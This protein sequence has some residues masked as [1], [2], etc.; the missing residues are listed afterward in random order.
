MGGGRPVFAALVHWC[1]R[2]HGGFKPQSVLP[3]QW[4]YHIRIIN[5]C[6]PQFQ[7]FVRGLKND[8]QERALKSIKYGTR[9]KFK[10][11]HYHVS[12]N[13][14]RHESTFFHSHWTLAANWLLFFL[15]RP[16]TI[17]VVLTDD[18]WLFK[19][20]FLSVQGFCSPLL[21]LPLPRSSPVCHS[22]D[23]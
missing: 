3:G 5:A 7:G 19:S 22:A 6:S 21:G 18:V 14:C 20:E 12:D 11:I 23:H 2:E 15:P 10:T 13:N 17:D 9:I 4:L 8:A 16:Q 1:P